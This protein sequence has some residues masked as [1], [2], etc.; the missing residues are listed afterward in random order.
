MAKS[1][2]KR[3]KKPLIDPAIAPTDEAQRHSDFAF[4]KGRYQRVPEIDRLRARNELDE[5]EYQALAFYRDQA[6]LAE[7]SPT[8]SCLDQRI[9]GTSDIGLSGAVVSAILTTS[10]IER[11]L[12]SLASLARAVAVEDKSLTQWCVDRFGGRERYDGKGKLIAIVP[13]GETTHDHIKMARLE[14]KFAARRIM[15]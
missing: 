10:R 7:R 8:K 3:K 1:S 5:R 15:A 11:E 2:A 12:G 9:S 13:I 14:L 4:F 6:A